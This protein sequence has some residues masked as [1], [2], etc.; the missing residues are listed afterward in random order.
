F[1]LQHRH[2]DPPPPLHL[3][4]PAPQPLSLFSSSLPLV[5]SKITP[6]SH[7]PHYKTIPLR[8]ESRCRSRGESSHAPES[9]HPPSP[10]SVSQATEPP[11]SSRRVPTQ[12]ERKK[13]KTGGGPD[14]S[15][16][17]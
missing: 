16:A 5:N 12:T 3:F 17:A 10:T 4:R 14:S 15:E 9:S 7:S 11:S 13:R 1:L 8:T 6:R 2:R